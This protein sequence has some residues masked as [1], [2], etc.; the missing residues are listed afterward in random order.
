MRSVAGY[1]LGRFLDHCMD[2]ELQFPGCRQSCPEGKVGG[3]RW[4]PLE[5][6]DLPQSAEAPVTLETNSGLP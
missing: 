6:R 5:L 2:A 4:V 1:V 3:S